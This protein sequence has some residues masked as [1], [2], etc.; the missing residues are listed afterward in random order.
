VLL[1]SEG[2]RLLLKDCDDDGCSTLDAFFYSKILVLDSQGRL[3]HSQM[4]TVSILIVS[5]A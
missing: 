2:V 3:P 5:C 1:R 4:V